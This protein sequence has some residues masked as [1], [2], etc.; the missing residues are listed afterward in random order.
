MGR[1][2]STFG[3][4]GAHRIDLAPGPGASSQQP[5]LAAGNTFGTVECAVGGKLDPSV[6]CG[7]TTT[8]T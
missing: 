8:S 7:D 6:P 1:T 4:L 5:V 2:P 3:G